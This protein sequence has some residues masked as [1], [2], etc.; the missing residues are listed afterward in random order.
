MRKYFVY[1]CSE[2]HKVLSSS[3]R[4]ER[5]TLSRSILNLRPHSKMGEVFLTHKD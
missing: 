1:F 2:I 4:G 3:I 5:K